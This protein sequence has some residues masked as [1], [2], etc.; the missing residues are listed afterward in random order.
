MNDWLARVQHDLV[1]RLL[2]PARDR[3]DL[4][5]KPAPGELEPRL[6]DDEGRPVGAVEL[7]STLRAEISGQDA[8]LDAFGAALEDAVAAARRGDLDGVLALDGAFRALGASLRKE[9]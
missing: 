3:R 9:T 4:G 7:W 2:W 8:A 1:K 5:G 6:V